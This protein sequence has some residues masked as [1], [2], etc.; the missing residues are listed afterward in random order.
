MLKY[1]KNLLSIFIDISYRAVK[2]IDKDRFLSISLILSILHETI[3]LSLSIFWKFANFSEKNNIFGKNGKK[4]L[5][6]TTIF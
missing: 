1:W 3:Y 2:K 4:F 5:G 6:D